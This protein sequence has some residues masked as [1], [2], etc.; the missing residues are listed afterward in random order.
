MYVVSIH[1]KG[2]IRVKCTAVPSSLNGALCAIP[3]TVQNF[4]KFKEIFFCHR[5]CRMHEVLSI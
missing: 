4:S 2:N 5:I 1:S 3:S